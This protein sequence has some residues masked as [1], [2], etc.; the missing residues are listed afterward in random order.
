VFDVTRKTFDE[1]M[2]P[3]YNPSD[4]IPVRGE[5]SRLWDSEGREYIDMACGIAVTGLGHCNPKLVAA[6]TEQASKLW[7]VSNIMTNEP[8]LRLASRLTEVTFADKIYF[9]NS[10]AEANEAALKLARKYASIHGA[11]EQR[12]ILAFNNSFHGRTL[13]TVSAGGQEKYTQGFEP[14]PGGIRHIDYNDIAALEQSVSSKTC[15]VIVELVQ[16][17]G[18]V[19]PADPAFIRRA[20]ELCDQFGA[21]LIFDEV[22]T[23]NLR[24]GKLFAYQA[25]GIT[26]DVLTTAKGMGGGFPIGAMLCTDKAAASLSFGTHGSTYGGNALGCAVALAVLEQLTDPAL[27]ANVAARSAQLFE[28]LS[29]LSERYGLFGKPRGMGL[30][31]GAPMSAAW[32]GKAKQLVQAAMGEG[33]WVLVAGPDVM[34]FVPPLT[35]SEAELEAAMSRL[36]RACAKLAD[37]KA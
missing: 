26:P 1:V 9:A 27:E 4:V 30:L 12:E 18:G 8:A 32:A 13:F 37:G 16:G 20:R 15:A 14:L 31:V 36:E 25:Y 21:L 11:P 19:L 35:M 23:G 28:S 22:Q 29:R 24:S 10:G 6:L 7:H 17:E 5:G 33:V 3:N 34:R 2:V